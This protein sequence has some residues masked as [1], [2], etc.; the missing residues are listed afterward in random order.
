MTVRTLEILRIEE[1]VNMR[2]VRL[3]RE[4][5]FCRSLKPGQCVVAINGR[6]TI[7]RI[8]DCRGSYTMYAPEKT[9]FDLNAI[10]QWMAEGLGVTICETENTKHER[11]PTVNISEIHAEQKARQKR[12][13]ARKKTTRRYRT[14]LAARKRA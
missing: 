2:F 11:Q 5:R 12:Y 3:I 14:P 10:R 13:H 1:N 8:L 4:E 6:E 7:A 9:R